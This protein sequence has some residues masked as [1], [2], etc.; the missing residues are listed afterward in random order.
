MTNAIAPVKAPAPLEPRRPAGAERDAEMMR[1][2]KAFEA[3]FVAQMLQ[4]SGLTEAL[5]SN[6]GFGG[7]AFSSLL[8]E[9]YAEKLVDK[10]GFGL[11][12]K[13]YEQLQA[14]GASNVERTNA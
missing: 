14:K 3:T 13:I 12:E 7:E 9:Q 6:G 4:H 8:V 10:G 5:S 11:A 1:N 2:A